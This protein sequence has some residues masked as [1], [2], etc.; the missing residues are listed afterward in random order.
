GRKNKCGRCQWIRAFIW[1]NGKLMLEMREFLSE[2]NKRWN[3]TFSPDWVSCSER[4]RQRLLNPATVSP[5][6]LEQEIIAMAKSY[7]LRNKASPAP[8]KTRLSSRNRQLFRHY[9]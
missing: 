9:I 6:L 7:K 5:L 2:M 8:Q 3:L 1:R 4:P